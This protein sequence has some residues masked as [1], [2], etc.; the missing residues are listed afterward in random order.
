MS[1]S[2]AAPILRAAPQLDCESGSDL[3]VGEFESG[4]EHALGRAAATPEQFVAEG[5]ECN[6]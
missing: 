1:C 2:E 3:G 4:I 6:P 5:A